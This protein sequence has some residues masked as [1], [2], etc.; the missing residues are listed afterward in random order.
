MT[1]KTPFVMT[2]AVCVTEDLPLTVGHTKSN[3]SGDKLLP[4]TFK[5]VGAISYQ[6][7]LGDRPRSSSITYLAVD[8]HIM[9]I[10]VGV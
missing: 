3:A 2:D 1:I 8:E 6:N 4:N 9:H 10:I 7:R 5:M